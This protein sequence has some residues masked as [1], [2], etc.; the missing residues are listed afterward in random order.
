MKIKLL[1]AAFL[2]SFV[3]GSWAQE[4]TE[5]EKPKGKINGKVFMNYHLDTTGDEEQTSAFELTR[6]YLGYKYKFNDQFSAAILFDAGKN[7]GGSDYTIFIKNAKIDYQANSWL[8]LTG[9]IFGLTQFKVQEKFWGY[10][11]LAKS[12]EDEYKFGSSADVGFMAAMKLTD[13]LT[14]DIFAVNGEGY[15]KLQ[16]PSGKNRYGVNLIYKPTKN[17]IL[18][19]YYDTMKGID[20]DDE[21]ENTIVSNIGFFAGFIIKD[22]F[23]IGG[24][25]GLLQNGENYR[26]PAKGKDLKGMSFYSTYTI[27]KRWNVFGRWDNLSSNTLPG[28]MMDWNISKDNSTYIA[29]VEFK[30]IKGVNTSINYRYTDYEDIERIENSFVYFNLEY[31]F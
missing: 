4:K 11:Y 18:K 27:N 10:R 20:V 3:L 21:N 7:S 22:K 17:F 1:L 14:L 24:E 15:Q 29:G 2:F 9:G 26:D 23:K 25:Y 30:P 5:E 31:F 8:K 13:G 28:E 16:D 19:A 12:L 6:A